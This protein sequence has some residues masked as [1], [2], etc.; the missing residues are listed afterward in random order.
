MCFGARAPLPQPDT[1]APVQECRISTKPNVGSKPPLPSLGNPCLGR[2]TDRP[3][4]MINKP[5]H[6]SPC[7]ARGAAALG[8]YFHVTSE[9]ALGMVTSWSP[10][11]KVQRAPCLLDRPRRAPRPG[12]MG[13]GSGGEGKSCILGGGLCR[14]SGQWCAAS[15]E[16]SWSPPGMNGIKSRCLDT[17]RVTWK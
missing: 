17:S 14:A 12:G 10:L 2:L 1:V 6:V 8:N 4:A 11:G 9:E 15:R 3:S 16:E 5:Y 7:V 13:A